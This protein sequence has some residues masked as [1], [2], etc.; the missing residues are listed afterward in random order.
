M[1]TGSGYLDPAHRSLGVLKMHSAKSLWPEFRTRFHCKTRTGMLSLAA[2]ELSCYGQ[3][4]ATSQSPWHRTKFYNTLAK[5][6]QTENAG[7]CPELAVHLLSFA[8]GFAVALPYPRP[9]RSP[10]NDFAKARSSLPST[11]ILRA[12]VPWVCHELPSPGSCNWAD[13]PPALRNFTKICW[14]LHQ[15]RCSV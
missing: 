3:R 11:P 10:E 4:T 1:T 8:R 9:A 14:T 6:G 15:L 13:C 2:S 5:A 7:C 12:P